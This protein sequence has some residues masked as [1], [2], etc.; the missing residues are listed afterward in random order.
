M[1]VQTI[2]LVFNG[3]YNSS[4]W[5]TFN[6]LQSVVPCPRLVRRLGDVSGRNPVDLHCGRVSVDIIQWS[7]HDSRSRI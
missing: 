3:P 6:Y 7:G 2:T 5:A 1:M 4:A